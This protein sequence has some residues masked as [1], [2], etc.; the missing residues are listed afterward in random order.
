MFS[1]IKF[2]KKDER[3]LF[4]ISDPILTHIVSRFLYQ[5]FLVVHMDMERMILKKIFSIAKVCR[6]DRSIMCEIYEC[7]NFKLL[8][9]QC[10]D[11]PKESR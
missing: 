2:F 10:I 1:D 5:D 7:F 3:L 11:L 8:R 4:R 9:I 6:Q